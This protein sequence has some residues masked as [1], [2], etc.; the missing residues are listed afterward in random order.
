MQVSKSKILLR[1]HAKT[2]FK[3]IWHYTFDKWGMNKANLYTNQ[4]GDST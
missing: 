3:K 4:L 1:P 2:D